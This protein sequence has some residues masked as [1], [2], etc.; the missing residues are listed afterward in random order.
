MP[1]AGRAIL[2]AAWEILKTKSPNVL[3][4][5]EVAKKAG[6]AVGLLYH[7]FEDRDDLVDAVREAQFLARIEADIVTLHAPF[8]QTTHHMICERTL[9]LMKP[10]A[11]LICF[12]AFLLSFTRISSS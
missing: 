9:N 5:S 1:E 8:D 10:E 12:S 4:V 2:E 3:R 11:I 6:V 7:Y